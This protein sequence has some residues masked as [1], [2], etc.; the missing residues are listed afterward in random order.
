MPYKNPAGRSGFTL[1]PRSR[2]SSLYRFDDGFSLSLTGHRPNLDDRHPFLLNKP[3]QGKHRAGGSNFSTKPLRESLR[4]KNQGLTSRQSE[5]TVRAPR[6]IVAGN[7]ASC[8]IHWAKWAHAT[9]Y[10]TLWSGSLSPNNRLGITDHDGDHR[11]PHP[12]CPRASVHPDRSGT[13][14]RNHSTCIV[15][16]AGGRHTPAVTTV[17]DR[18]VRPSI[19]R[20]PRP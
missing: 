16:R 9:S 14:L 19:A 10:R 2:D 11:C 5:N 1:K 6:R 17:A 8:P 3:Y 20:L 4:S 12:P 18:T 7:V 13:E 15:R